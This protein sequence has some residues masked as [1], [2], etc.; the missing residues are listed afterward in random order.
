MTP[1]E[2]ALKTA[3]IAYKQDLVKIG[4][5]A[6][7][8]GVTAIAG[9]I[10]T[11]F[12]TKLKYKHEK[13]E[14]VRTSKNNVF[15]DIATN[16]NKYSAALTKYSLIYRSLP[17]QQSKS[18]IDEYKKAQIEFINSQGTIVLAL[19]TLGLYGEFDAH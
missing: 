4:L 5:P 18:D 14:N 7:L 17:P 9:I 2:I 19:T 10:G 1:E 6:L 3:E 15:H 12:I 11:Y 13:E 8:T 16:V